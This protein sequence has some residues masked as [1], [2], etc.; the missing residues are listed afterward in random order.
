MSLAQ[1]MSS[2]LSPAE[3]ALRVLLVE[4][5]DRDAERAKA[6]LTAELG[7]R[8][9]LQRTNTL[10]E[11]IRVLME[12]AFDVAL[13]E[14]DL[15]DA[16]GLATLAGIRGAAPTM[17]VVVYARALDEGLAVRALRAGAQE[18]LTKQDT[19]SETLPRLIRFAIER[20]RHLAALEAARIAA[21]HRAT[22]DPLTKLANRALFLDHLERALAFGSR[23][24]RK[25][26]ILFVDLDGFKG[27]NDTL[28]HARGD[29]LLQLVAERLQ[30]CVRRSDSVARLGGDEFVVL[31]PDVTS[32]RDVAHVRDTILSCLA[33][34]VVIDGLDGAGIDAS[35]GGAMS[36][37][38]GVSAEEL[39]DAADASMYREKYARRRGRM[40]TPITGVAALVGA[41]VTAQEASVPHRR[42][43]RLRSAVVAN[44]F[45]VHFQPMIDVVGS[46]IVGAEALLR[47]RDP[48]RGLVM[49]ASFLPLA[50]DTGLIVPIGEFVLRVACNAVMRW[51]RIPEGA[52]ARVSVNLSAVQ[53]REREFERRVAQI[54]H[55][56][57]CP[58]DALVLELTESSAMVDGD[59]AIE[60][61]KALKSL[62]LQLVVDDFGVGYASLNFLREAPVDGLKIDRR[63]VTN[64]LA[65]T[66]DAAIVGALVRLGR[67]L[68]LRVVA[69]G[70]ESLEQSQRLQRMQ[71]FE[72]QGR[73]FSDALSA[74]QFEAL[75]AASPVATVEPRSWAV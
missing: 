59:V 68:G 75:L 13:V 14:L 12:A 61:L 49:P 41:A 9:A 56:T 42:E 34:P 37:L 26:G 6:A 46:K 29:Q 67:G 31:L 2:S 10:V 30:G 36:P 43:S 48:E 55:E 58:A 50:E 39:L 40:P 47:W 65:D 21:A 7:S 73:H 57:G 17:P 23:Y 25:T 5:D 35:V 74:P 52:G 19:R 63:F 70:V 22:H 28:G 8:V 1:N 11:S 62:G 16:T 60:T 53:L 3:G 66:R 20:Q 51:R 24:A 54:L 4:N 71:C 64:M 44:E 18:C 72:Q 32:R 27:I 38:D 45:E 69:E 33:E 15:S